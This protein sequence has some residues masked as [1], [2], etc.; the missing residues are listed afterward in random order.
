MNVWQ[1]ASSKLCS[2]I[3]RWNDADWML[4]HAA[5]THINAVTLA[6]N[7]TTHDLQVH[8]HAGR[9]GSALRYFDLDGFEHRGRLK[10]QFWRELWLVWLDLPPDGRAIVRGTIEGLPLAYGDWF[11]FVHRADLDKH[12]PA[13]TSPPA[14]APSSDR[15]KPGKRAKGDWPM[16][17]ARELIRR[18]RNG[19]AEPTAPQ[20]LQ[21]LEDSIGWQPDIRLMQKLL[22]ELLA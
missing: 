13:A 19:K 21:F 8:L 15:R 1:P 3:R 7:L 18:A 17:V 6:R 16:L 14:G 12:Y 10:K 20:M 11:F 22:K 4:L 2:A 5:L 9:I